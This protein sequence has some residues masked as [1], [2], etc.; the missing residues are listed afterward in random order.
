MG[1]GRGEA[2]MTIQ[3]VVF[4][5]GNVLL[6]WEPQEIV[7]A[8]FSDEPFPQELTAKIFKSP[9]WYDLNL[10]KLTE[11]E[12]IQLYSQQ[13]AI[14][15]AK[16]EMLMADIKESLTPIDGSLEFLDE[17]HA[18]G[19]PL[20][21]ITDNVKEIMKF[22]KAQ[23]SFFHKFSGIAVS[24]EIGV[25]KPSALI[26]QHL[27]D[28]YHLIPQE[29]VFIDDLAKN[30]QGAQDIG[31]QGIHFTNAAHCRMELQRLGV[32]A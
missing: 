22:L 3:N 9:I 14:P 21:S 17:L 13:L 26:Y 1:T 29:T 10:G 20:Y 32:L 28:S 12:A 25:L 6:R 16:L 23:Y 31:L 11:K 18:Q 30:V 4:D 5:I 8:H 27:I 2:K 24:A 15:V 7:Q 19:T